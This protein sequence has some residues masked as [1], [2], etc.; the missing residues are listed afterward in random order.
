[1]RLD[2]K[3]ALVTG[4]AKGIGEGIA[5]RFL[6]AG[7]KVV[8][9][10]IDGAALERT[11]EALG[12]IG[13]VLAVAGDVAN[14]QDAKTAVAR[15]TGHFGHLDVLVNNAGIAIAGRIPD[16]SVADWDRQLSV[17]LKAAYLFSKYAIP[18]MAGRGGAIVNISSVHA[19][20][21]YEA[22]AAYDAS[23]AGML[24]LT[25]TL[26][27]DHGRDRIRVNAM[28]P[29]YV[30]TPMTEEWLAAEPDPEATRRQVLSF[31]PL[32]RMGTPADIAEAA[33]FLA[34]DSASFITGAC[35]VVDGG[36]TIQGR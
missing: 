5:R 15:A 22:S 17:N 9:F 4:A 13:E 31:H 6:E 18:C 25:R 24:G 16:L 19:F 11:A 28:C 35:L 20:A 32:G 21:S 8:L 1:M 36:M 10:D 33:L 27:L 29:G 12:V 2:D 26:A 30:S 7:A 23:K 34:S 3:V 14:E